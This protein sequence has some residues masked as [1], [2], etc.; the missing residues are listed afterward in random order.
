MSRRTVSRALRV[1]T[2]L[3]VSLALIAGTP[4]ASTALSSFNFST[5]SS[6]WFYLPV[7]PDPPAAPYEVVIADRTSRSIKL[8][9]MDRS[10]VEDGHQLQRKVPGGSWATIASFPAVSGVQ[11]WTDTSGLA[12]DTQYCY[13]VRVY[14][15]DGASFSPR[16]CAY[17]RHEESRQ[18]WRVQ[19]RINTADVPEAGSDD[20]VEVRL[21]SAVESYVPFGNSTWL[22]HGG[23]DFEPGSSH[24]YN[25]NQDGIED[26]T[27]ITE[28]EISKTGGDGIC[29]ESFSLRVNDRFVYGES[30]GNTSATCHWLDN[31]GGHSNTFSVSH[32]DLRASTPWNEYVQPLPVQVDYSELPDFATGTL[33]LDNAELVSRIESMTGHLLHDS[34]A[35]WG[36]LDGPEYV[37]ISRALDQAVRVTLDLEADVPWL[38]DPEVDVSFDLAFELGPNEDGELEFTVETRNVEANADFNILLEILDFFIP[39]GPVASVATGDGTPFCIPALEDS[40]ED[41]ARA[42]VTPVLDPVSLDLG[43]GTPESWSVEV[44]ALGDVIVTVR[45]DLREPAAPVYP[46][47]RLS[48]TSSYLSF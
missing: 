30:F 20:P 11:E 46:V 4:R 1:A 8:A 9:W 19:M 44:N 42:A 47:Y 16:S 5:S 33:T 39:C 43:D 24:V 18:V 31:E 6:W 10:A 17:T 32:A 48:P 15:D 25:L 28:I 13:R 14:N 34:E 22:D 38:P 35:Y 3:L 2:P 45:M 27:D 41:R 21:N 40:I 36:G 23:D 12:D 37:E 7:L 26:L 29:I